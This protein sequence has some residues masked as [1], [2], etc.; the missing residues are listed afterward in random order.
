MD[1]LFRFE[2][3]VHV[4]YKSATKQA[5][6]YNLKRRKRTF[7]IDLKKAYN[8]FLSTNNPALMA[9][10]SGGDLRVWTIPIEYPP[11][12]WQFMEIN[13]LNWL[14]LLS[15]SNF[16]KQLFKSYNT[17]ATNGSEINLKTKLIKKKSFQWLV[18]VQLFNHTMRHNCKFYR[19]TKKKPRYLI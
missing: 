18:A 15:S 9:I 2:E 13:Y 8:T 16:G 4:M 17:T 19:W 7:Q 1:T 6:V 14:A 10:V 11:G 3:N 12:E 5:F